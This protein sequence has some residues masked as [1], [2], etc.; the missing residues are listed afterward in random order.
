MI[1]AFGE[2]LSSPILWIVALGFAIWFLIDL[3][4]FGKKAREFDRQSGGL[5]TSIL[6]SLFK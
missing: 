2:W 4:K 5:L 6:K 3:V 1:F